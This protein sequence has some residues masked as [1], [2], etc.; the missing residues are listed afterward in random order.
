MTNTPA[1]AVADVEQT[2][3]A[4][5]MP[6]SIADSLGIRAGEALLTINGTEVHDEL[7]YRYLAAEECLELA[8]L[9]TDGSVRT[10]EI[11]KGEDE[12]L[13]IVL[14]DMRLMKC[15]NRCVFCFVHQNPRGLRKSLYF[16][17]EDY[18]YSFL[19]GHYVTLAKATDEEIQRII[20]LRL[21]PIYISTHTTRP[22]LR[23][24]LLGIHGARR[25]PE[26]LSRF[27]RAG[28]VTH[29]QVVLCPGLNDGKELDRTVTE[30]AGHYPTASSVALVPVGLTEHRRNLPAL[31]PPDRQYARATL[32]LTEAYQRRFR[33]EVGTSFVYAAD[34]FFLLAETPPPPLEDYDDFPQVGN[35]VGLYRMLL[36]R[37]ERFMEEAP[38]ES[39]APLV[40]H[41]ITGRVAAPILSAAVRRL[42]A[43]AGVHLE[44]VVAKNTLFGDSIGVAGL[45]SGRCFLAAMEGVRP[46]GEVFIPEV[47]LRSEDR[48]FLD[49]LTP[50]DLEDRLRAPVVPGDQMLEVFYRRIAGSS[51]SGAEELAEFSIPVD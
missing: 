51:V 25:I 8:I 35:G 48:H 9:G 19:Y 12:D 33:E 40:G 45:L 14:A 46:L 43:I 3:I 1:G 26:L 39:A 44:L 10:L 30:L 42:N 38:A 23:D 28:I 11:D 16:K 22:E 4:E 47:A 50:A 7:G 21:S 29:H 32:L 5:V 34:E 31:L 27:A 2:R 18:R 49:D 6:G 13:G 41:V 37:L 17:D 24:Y 15:R 36:D 20:D